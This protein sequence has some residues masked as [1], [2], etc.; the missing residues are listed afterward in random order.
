MAD[1]PIE[2]TRVPPEVP[3]G[4]AHY[5]P[6][7]NESQVNERPGDVLEEGPHAGHGDSSSVGE[8]E[9]GAEMVGHRQDEVALQ[10]LPPARPQETVDLTTRKAGH[11]VHM[12]MSQVRTKVGDADMVG[13]A[14]GLLG[15]GGS[16]PGPL[17]KIREGS[18]FKAVIH[19]EFPRQTLVHWHGF[20]GLPNEFD[21]SPLTQDP[22]QPGEQF[23]YKIPGNVPGLYPFHPHVEDWLGRRLGA[24]GAV[25]VEPKNPDYYPPAHRTEVIMLHDVE[26][27]DG[28]V[29]TGDPDRPTHVLMGHFGN[30]MLI[31]GKT[32]YRLQ[33]TA[34][35][36]L[37]FH[38]IN[39]ADVRPFNV[40]ILGPD[41]Q[42]L[43]LKIVGSDSRRVPEEQFTESVLNA[44]FLLINLLLGV[45]FLS[46]GLSLVAGMRRARRAGETVPKPL[47]RDPTNI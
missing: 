11:A 13:V 3:G 28:H 12:S 44:I 47:L 32:D 5:T 34:G 23:V 22:I 30:V 26:V 16:I 33:A 21:G 14:Y 41:R 46:R 40:A 17:I 20:A 15:S 29:V 18:W 43:R 42:T 19:N 38:L 36:I 31:N 35:E 6:A 9:G 25:L 4:R 37:R 7:V 27:K 24:V 8:H 1:F 10:E 45:V 2:G 39:P